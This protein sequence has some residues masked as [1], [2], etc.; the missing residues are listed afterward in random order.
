MSSC[1]PVP[2]GGYSLACPGEGCYDAARSAYRSSSAR[3][4]LGP[5]MEGEPALTD[6]FL[7]KVQL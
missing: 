3:G 1:K 7:K 2:C 4:Y 5:P 6:R